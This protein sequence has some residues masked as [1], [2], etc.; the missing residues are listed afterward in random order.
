GSGPRD[1]KAE[2]KLETARY[3]QEQA[4]YGFHDL[5]VVVAV[6][7]RDKE[8]LDDAVRQVVKNTSGYMR[9]VRPP[10]GQG[11]LAQFFTTTAASKIDVFVNNRIETSNGVAVMMPFGI[12][13]PSR[14][15]GIMWMIEGQTPI[16]F[17]PMR[18][19]AGRKRAG[20]AVVLGKTGSGKTLSA[21]VWGSRM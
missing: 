8:S 10:Y 18:D 11:P 3:Y 9:L 16:L 15:D 12:R 14:T 6:E 1:V 13:R 21:F 4:E 2:R 17:N 7:G 19:S 20:H 5:R